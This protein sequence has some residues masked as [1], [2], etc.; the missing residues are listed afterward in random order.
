MR[1]EEELQII[2]DKYAKKSKR[3]DRIIKQSD[4]QQLQLLKLNN[5][6]EEQKAELTK[7]YNYDVQQQLTA[8]EKLESLIVNDVNNQ[9]QIVFKASDILSGDYYSVFKLRDGG[10]LLYLIDGQGHGVAPA[11]TI[12]GVCTTMLTL[13]ET[14]ESFESFIA[15]IFTEIRKFLGDIEQLSFTLI[16]IS[17]D[18]TKVNYVSGG[19]YP[20]LIQ[21]GGVISKH[22]ANNLPFMEFSPLPKVKTVECSSFESL[23]VYSDGLVEDISEDLEKFT[24]EEILKDETAIESLNAT[25]ADKEFEDDITVIRYVND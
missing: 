23:I 25:I 1:T 12:H 14:C 2:I 24:P 22:K 19:M 20:F 3:L 9:T 13:I 7:L 8:K 21:D 16:H 17:A 5:K 6:I 11:L 10:K 18:A 15:K 4:K